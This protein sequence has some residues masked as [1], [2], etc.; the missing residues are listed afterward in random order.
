MSRPSSAMR[1]LSMSVCRPKRRAATGYIARWIDPV[2]GRKRQKLL[3]FRRKREAYES[4]AEL[5]ERIESGM[6]IGGLSW[7]DFCARY[8]KQA[9][10]RRG[11]KSI[12]AWHTVKWF[13]EER[14]PLATIRGANNLWIDRFLDALETH[15]PDASINTIATYLARLRAALTWAVKKRYLDYLPLIEIQRDAKPRSRAVTPKEFQRMLD[16]VATVRPRDGVLWRRLL[17]G[18]F[19]TGLRISELL[20]LSWDADADVCVVEGRHPII[21]LRKQKNLKRQRIPITPEA[22]EVI[23][24]TASR[25]GSVFGIR[26]TPKSAVRVIGAIGL[27]SGVVTDK[28]T[29]KHATSHDI[30][31]AFHDWCEDRYGKAIAEMLLRHADAETTAT[32]YDTQAAERA[33]DLLWET[34]K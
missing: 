24:D 22:W 12:Q 13:I 6:D 29:G 18:Q 11:F 15:R 2:S 31:R 23:S 4:A 1:R 25:S 33:A 9:I 7:L 14:C 20:A 27:E 28:T 5:A 3:G 10:G 17:K 19:Y 16:A 8:E 32:F 26:M 30:R 34:G 21:F